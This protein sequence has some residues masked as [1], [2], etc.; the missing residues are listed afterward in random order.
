MKKDTENK[1]LQIEINQQRIHQHKSTD[2]VEYLRTEV[3]WA[4]KVIRPD[5]L[6]IKKELTITMVH[7]LEH[8]TF[9]VVDEVTMLKMNF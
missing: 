1:A 8:I 9:N 2:Q 5:H 7:I 4:S 6:E 3:E